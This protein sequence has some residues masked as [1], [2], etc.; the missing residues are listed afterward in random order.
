MRLASA[1]LVIFA[2]AAAGIAWFTG[3]SPAMLLA[4]HHP[5]PPP[6]AAPV[7]VVTAVVRTERVPITLPGIGTVQAYNTVNVATQVDGQI[8][9]ILFHE[10]QDVKQGDPLAI[11]DPRP[12]TA[13]LQQQEA[14]RARDQAMLQGAELDLARYADLVTRG[15]ASRQQL[16]EQRALV[17][18]YQ[19]SVAS[20]EAAMT[21]ARVQLDYTTITAPISGRVGI[22]QVDLGNYLRAGDGKTIVVITQLQPISVVFTIS[23]DAVARSNLGLGAMHLPVTALAQ[24]GRTEL[25]HGTVEMVDNEVDPSSGTIKLKAEFPNATLKLWP[26]GFVNGRLVVATRP[27]AITIPS[28]AVRHGPRCDFAWVVRPDETAVTRCVTAGQSLAGRTLI[29]RGLAQGARVVVDGEYRLAEGAHV[30]A[31]PAR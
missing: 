11:I 14:A 18:Q 21:F 17:G 26:G 25:D 9:Q 2:L 30:T 13:R 5:P 19:G 3:V 31:T 27:D 6:A 4:A 20:D 15:F 29:E 16:D 24:D 23:A 10:G 22:R 12:F 8:T 7:P 28:A 1:L